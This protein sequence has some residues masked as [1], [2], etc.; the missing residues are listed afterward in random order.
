MTGVCSRPK[1]SGKS[2]NKN[3]SSYSCS[4]SMSPPCK[5]NPDSKY[6]LTSYFKS[7]SIRLESCTECEAGIS[8]NEQQEPDATT[9]FEPEP[10]LEEQPELA[11][12]ILAEN[13]TFKTCDVGMPS[14]SESESSNGEDNFLEAPLK[15]RSLVGPTSWHLL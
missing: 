7:S 8:C 1:T 2:Q 12:D 11:C 14:S 9:P 15:T 6:M 5:K 13:S 10:A 3:A 4:R